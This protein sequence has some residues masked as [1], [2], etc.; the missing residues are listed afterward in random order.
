MDKQI[1]EQIEK[2][3]KIYKEELKAYCDQV[4]PEDLQS[5]IQLHLD[6]LQQLN[7]KQWHEDAQTDAKENSQNHQEDHEL[8]KSQEVVLD[9]NYDGMSKPNHK[10][11]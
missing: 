5:K 2:E 4:K 1:K 10:K 9:S 3:Y 11:G 6:I 8:S 7:H